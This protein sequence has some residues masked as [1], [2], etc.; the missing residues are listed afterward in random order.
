MKSKNSVYRAFL[1][2][3]I[4]GIA[5]GM[6]I[7]RLTGMAETATT[8]FWVFYGIAFAICV[9]LCCLSAFHMVP[10]T[11]S[12]AIIA[13]RDIVA[14]A[15]LFGLA[16]QAQPYVWIAILGISLL[17]LVVARRESHSLADRNDRSTDVN[18]EH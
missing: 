15:C 12:S 17:W 8:V 3:L 14:T 2:V 11:R 9:I 18:L 5:L 6:H 16:W 4:G 13:A 1:P 10:A 7:S